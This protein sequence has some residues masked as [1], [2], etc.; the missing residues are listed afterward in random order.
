MSKEWMNWLLIFI[1]VQRKLTQSGGGDMVQDH[2]LKTQV[3]IYP[4]ATCIFPRPL[5]APPRPVQRKPW[6]QLSALQVG[7]RWWP[8]PRSS[9]ALASPHL[10]TH[11]GTDIN[12]YGFL[13]TGSLWWAAL[14]PELLFGTT[15]TL[16]GPHHRST[17][18]S[19]FHFLLLPRSGTIPNKHVIPK[20]HLK[21]CFQKTHLLTWLFSKGPVKCPS[22]P[23]GLAFTSVLHQFGGSRWTE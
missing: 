8:S 15:Q 11:Q 19:Q 7:L 21:F 13:P 16:W 5:P 10:M 14:A 1:W 12:P 20:L 9:P 6:L 23:R 18:P 2:G 17:G 3:T 22:D 4:V